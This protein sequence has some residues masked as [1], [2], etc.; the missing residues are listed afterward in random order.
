MQDVDPHHSRSSTHSPAHA[1]SVAAA[2]GAGTVTDAAQLPEKLPV[3]PGRSTNSLV[4]HEP[5]PEQLLEQLPVMHETADIA[6]PDGELPKQLPVDHEKADPAISRS[7][8]PL[9]SGDAD[10]AQKITQ[11][12]QQ[13]PGT[14]AK[15]E[16]A[17]VSLC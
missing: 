16:N 5:P 11:L 12:P 17:W 2:A 13:L 6:Q 1:P 14:P 8:L 15:P 9:D 3:D 10:V 4:N 7:Q